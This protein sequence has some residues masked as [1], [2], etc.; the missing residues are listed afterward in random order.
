MLFLPSNWYCIILLN[1]SN[2]KKTRWWLVGLANKNHGVEKASSRCRSLLAATIDNDLR[3]GDTK[4]QQ[5]D[6][7]Q[8]QYYIIVLCEV[9]GW[10]TCDAEH[11]LM[12]IWQT[13]LNTSGMLT[14]SAMQTSFC[15]IWLASVFDSM[16][17]PTFW[18]G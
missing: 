8:Y 10:L 16:Q 17:N 3:Y 18:V 13:I 9:I 7:I 5:N 15:L 11:D 1:I 2:K 4:T 14:C 12:Q 6:I